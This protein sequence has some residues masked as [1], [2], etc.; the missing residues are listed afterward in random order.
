MSNVSKLAKMDIELIA[1]TTGKDKKKVGLEE[2]TLDDQQRVITCPCG[3]RPMQK[4]YIEGKGRAVFAGS[5]CRKCP[6]LKQCSASK[7]GHNYTIIYDA[8]SLRLRERRL[9]EKTEEFQEQYR[10][11]SGI[12]A[13]FG[14]LKQFT[15]L[16][17]L[18]IRGKFAVFN[19]MNSIMAVHNI[20]QM[21]RFYKMQDVKEQENFIIMTKTS[22]TTLKVG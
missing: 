7:Q 22:Y 17:R 9:H 20:M 13:L 6:M 5:T 11:R 1:P 19:A 15:P 10:L 12:E 16:R 3:K 14:R 4:R 18:G 21:A 8:R 2:C